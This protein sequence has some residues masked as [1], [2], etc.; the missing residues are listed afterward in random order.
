MIFP[1]FFESQFGQACFRES[2]LGI[3]FDFISSLIGEYFNFLQQKKVY[4]VFDYLFNQKLNLFA[5]KAHKFGKKQF[6]LIHDKFSEGVGNSMERVL[7][8]SLFQNKEKEEGESEN[9]KNYLEGSRVNYIV[10]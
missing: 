8:N 6:G 4:E 9:L 5:S 2:V 1:L 10:F 7:I 3:T